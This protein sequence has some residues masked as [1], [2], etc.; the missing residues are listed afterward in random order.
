[1]SK[2]QIQPVSNV[3]WV[4]RE[5]LHANDYNPNNVFKPEMRLLKLS[6]LED[7][8]TLPLVVSKTGDDEYEI[9]DGFH[10]WTLSNEPEIFAMTD[11][12]VPVVIIDKPTRNMQIAS[13]VRYNRARGVHHLTKMADIVSEMSDELSQDE[14]MKQLG[15]EDEEVIRLAERGNMSKRG[16]GSEF[17]KERIP[18]LREGVTIKG[19]SDD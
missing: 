14:I 11:G 12:L 17:G 13:T 10:R 15:M 1:M 5:K 4:E 16:S 7:G 6:L 18:G 2:E 9:I 3:I 19:A 8:W